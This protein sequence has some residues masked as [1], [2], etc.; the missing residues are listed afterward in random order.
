MSHTSETV[1][2]L[3]GVP[4]PSAFDQSHLEEPWENYGGTVNIGYSEQK[5]QL[6]IERENT[7]KLVTHLYSYLFYIVRDQ[8]IRKYY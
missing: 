1:I 2:F 6:N 4:V 3:N 7:D 8:M 5:K